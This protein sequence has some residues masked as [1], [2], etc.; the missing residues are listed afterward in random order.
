MVLLIPDT[1]SIPGWTL[2]ATPKEFLLAITVGCIATTLFIKATTIRNLVNHFKLDELTAIE[3][4]EY[5][6]A[7]ALMHHKVSEQLVKYEER[8]YIDSAIAQELLEKHKAAFKRACA[9]VSSLSHE[10]QEDL[11][12]RVLRIFAIG[13]EKRHLKVLYDHHEVTES[14]FRRIQGKLKLQL[15]AIEDGDLAPDVTIHA[16]GRDIFEHL[17]QFAIGKRNTTQTFT[18]R[19]MYYRAQAII[20]RKVLKELALLEKASA[21]IFTDAAVTHV[22]QL[23]STFKQNAER[24]LHNLSASDESAAGRLAETLAQSSVQSIEENVLADIFEKELIT[25]KLFIA[26]NHETKVGRL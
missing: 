17:F 11:A 8:G 16:D 1:L 26:L 23:Y 24:K 9:Q 10:R 5:Q 20:S 7:R 12:F 13:I 14:V 3:E 21:N 22:H 6:E 25:Q 19:Y 15:E 4:V 2:D 18:E